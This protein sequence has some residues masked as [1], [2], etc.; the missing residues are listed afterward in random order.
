M[1]NKPTDRVDS[2]QVQPNHP[3]DDNPRTNAAFQA[4][5]EAAAAKALAS[6]AVRID[7]LDGYRNELTGI[8]TSELDKTLGGLN[9]PMEFVVRFLTG[10]DCENRWRG[11]DVGGRIVET[12]PNEMMREGWELTIQEAEDEKLDAFPVPGPVIAPGPPKPRSVLEA[13]DDEGAQLAEALQDQQEE[14][15]AAAA[16]AEGLEYEQAFGGG[17]VLV[18]ADDGN[19]DLTMPLDETRIK[20]IKH[21]TAFR[22][23]WD[24]E[25]IAWRYYNDPRAPKYGLPEIYM[26][27][28]LGVPLSGAPAPG[29]NMTKVPVMPAGPTGALIFYV[30][31]SRLLVFPGKAVSRR[32][33]VQMRGWGDSV[34]TRVDEVLSQYGQTWG[35]VSNLMQDWALAVLKMDGLAKLLAAND[36][37]SNG[38]VA[39]RMI[40][41]NMSKS[42][43]RTLLIDKEEDYTRQVTPLTGIADVL[44]QFSH[45]L[46]AAADMPV[47]LLMGQAP[48]GLNATGD[49]DIRFF[50]DRIAARQKKV[51][52]PQVQRLV[53]LLM[54]AKEGPCKGVEPE[55][56]AVEMKP[57]WQ[58]TDAEM[59][60]VRKTQAETDHIYITDSVVTP[61]EVTISRFGGSKWSGD[62]V[63]DFQGR[64]EMAKV[65]EDKQAEAEK[66]AKEAATKMAQ[67]P[68]GQAP[69]TTNGKPVGK[70]VA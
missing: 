69:G 23:G 16:I 12:I 6:G 40:A 64:E 4:E 2:Y 26:L 14:L 42:I 61:E 31:E 46:A 34:F 3:S 68:P 66:A 30:H 45:R 41:M 25:V 17:V 52:L 56:W 62:T 11:S 49:A 8:G 15:G 28:N 55:K 1:A 27:R 19:T 35:S 37:S 20:S 10:V 70:A 59:A 32:A 54:L 67:Q 50:Y 39:K 24:G 18:G 7:N 38:T 60:T 57:L 53:R 58:M 44:Q 9:G 21:L 43:A 33:R 47:T 22:G 48:A 65:Q 13:P 36:P 29:E 5:V 51:L 63:I